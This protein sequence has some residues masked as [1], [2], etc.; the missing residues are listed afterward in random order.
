M[1]ET[2]VVTAKKRDSDI[3]EVIILKNETTATHLRL[4]LL[5]KG[6][7]DNS[8]RDFLVQK[9]MGDRKVQAFEVKEKKIK[10]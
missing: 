10:L 7:I 4:K 5:F 3:V 9:W 8:Q 1:N 2:K 6:E